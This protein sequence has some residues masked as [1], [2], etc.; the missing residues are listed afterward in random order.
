MAAPTSSP[1][2]R[3]R[4]P[5][6]RKA[7]IALAA[8]ELFCRRGYH[9]VGVD[10]IA[11]A[12]G[13][14]GPA[15]YRH[16]RT[17]QAI[18]AHAVAELSDGLATAA[19]PAEDA[20]TPA[21]RLDSALRNLAAFAVERRSVT[22]LYQWEDRHLP[23]DERRAA[24][25][26]TR[27]AVRSIRA[28]LLDVRP[29]LDRDS[30]TLLTLATFSVLGSLSTH[31]LSLPK[32]RTEAL[33][34]EL[35]ATVLALPEP[36][37]PQ[38]PADRPREEMLRLV[39]RRE[40]L[41]AEAVHLFHLRGFQAVSME[42]IGTRAGINASSLYR[43]FD[44]KGDLLAAIYH[45]A[46]ERLSDAATTALTGA[47]DP[48]EALER[49]IPTYV[50]IA[51]DQAGLVSVYLSENDNLPPGDRETLRAAQRRHVDEWVR[52][53]GSSRGDEP[54]PETRLRVYAAL[55]VVTDLARARLTSPAF[56]EELVAAL[57][58]S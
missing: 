25:A 31:R 15:I 54:A 39:S 5:K 11:D 33:V 38:P 48:G 18:L 55:N 23:D 4:R 43:H 46:T 17:K 41:L 10:E 40:R 45:R 47:R 16:F 12:V 6:N 8:A 28:L 32:G 53:V 49:L 21:D 56:G 57:L 35:A 22:R 44:G 3:A 2:E 14:T 58:T 42:E 50:R 24:N 20:G 7:Q 51:F 36:P 29:E 9:S 37:A 30:A 19:A 13:I 27:V 1:A 34:R 52:L 26:R